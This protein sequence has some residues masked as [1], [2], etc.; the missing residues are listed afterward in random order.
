MSLHKYYNKGLVQKLSTLSTEL[1]TVIHRSFPRNMGFPD[2]PQSSPQEFC[3][4]R[5]VLLVDI[6]FIQ[7]SCQVSIFQNSRIFSFKSRDF[8]E[9]KPQSIHIKEI[10]ESHSSITATFCGKGGNGVELLACNVPGQVFIIALAGDHGA[11][12]PAQR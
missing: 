7:K 9:K 6:K 3:T 1:S 5:C 10:L 2:Y 11:V 12:I 8:P 4:S